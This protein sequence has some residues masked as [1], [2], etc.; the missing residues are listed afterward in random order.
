MQDDEHDEDVLEQDCVAVEDETA[1]KESHVNVENYS[2]R[3]T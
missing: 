1:R 3:A 2:P